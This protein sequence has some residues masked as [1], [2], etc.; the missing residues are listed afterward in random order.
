METSEKSRIYEDEIAKLDEI[1]KDL[2]Q[3]KKDLIEGLKKQAAFMYTTLQEL[4]ETLNEDGA[5]ELFVQGHQRILREH[6]AAKTYN[7]MIRNYMATCKALSD[8]IPGENPDSA[9]DEL[10]EFVKRTKGK[11]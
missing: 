8:L 9:K 10:M 3:P 1:L 7:A 11:K 6:P 5:V 4:Q 2:P